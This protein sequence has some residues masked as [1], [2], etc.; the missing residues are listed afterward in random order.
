MTPEIPKFIPRNTLP[1]LPMNFSRFLLI[2]S[3]FLLLSSG[4]LHAQL[5]SNYA[6]CNL[7][8]LTCD[9]PEILP[10]DNLCFLNDDWTIQNNKKVRVIGPISQQSDIF[11]D[12]EYSLTFVF[13]EVGPDMRLVIEKPADLL[14]PNQL[15]APGKCYFTVSDNRTRKKFGPGSD[16]VDYVT[17]T[18]KVKITE[19]RP[20]TGDM[21]FPEYN[22]QLD[23][24]LQKV[25]RS[26]A[27]PV[28]TGPMIRIKG[29][30]KV[31][32]N[33]NFVDGQ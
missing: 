2:P 24:Y 6:Y 15:A 26:G 10:F 23:V 33:A 28:L 13:P 32:R 11:H 22:A 1:N 21:L 20:M 27:M 17:V 31:E 25:D 30:L 4:S 18:G 3:L 19:Y 7:F 9:H 8:Y 16:E 5:D 12:Y 14:A 29:V